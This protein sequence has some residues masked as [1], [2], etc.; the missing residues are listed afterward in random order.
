MDA[1]PWQMWRDWAAR[2][3]ASFTS[4]STIAA[5]L[6]PPGG[7]AFAPWTASFEQ[8][9][10]E[11][12]SYLEQ[13]ARTSQGSAPATGAAA[14]GSAMAEAARRFADE[15]RQQFERALPML[16]SLTVPGVSS[17]TGTMGAPAL[18]P[19]R[20]HQQ[21]AERLMQAAARTQEAQQRL[22]RL[23]SD[24]LR[25][26]AAS[27][28]SKLIAAP[29]AGADSAGLRALY[30]AWIDC[31]EQAYARIAHGKEFCEAL[32]LLINSMSAGRHEMQAGLEAW[33]KSLDLPTR[34][35]LNSLNARLSALEA[36][37]LR[38]PTQAPSAAPPP[39]AAKP[40]AK[41]GRPSNKGAGQPGSPK[42][43]R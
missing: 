24:A 42:A 38:Q 29:P 7:A 23:W 39:S 40:R 21:R 34:S 4:G 5:G 14:S 17:M 8:F 2:A 27:F 15:L 36:A 11:A 41:T 37:L 13:L 20:E 25:D 16:A 3:A 22:Q 6:G 19:L 18:G 1:D 26:A 31:A 9:A 10:T 28:T 43:K 33:A 30:D 32:A 35:E 12:R